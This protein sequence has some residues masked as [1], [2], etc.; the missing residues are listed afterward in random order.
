MKEYEVRID[1]NSLIFSVIAESEAEAIDRASDI[2]Y[3]QS[4]YDLFKRADYEVKEIGEW[5]E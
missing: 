4:L 5:V 2:A 1:L 3:D